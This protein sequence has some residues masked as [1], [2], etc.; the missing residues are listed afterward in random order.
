M[1]EV[2]ERHLHFEP[3]AL[4]RLD[5]ELTIS[6]ASEH[7]DPVVLARMR[8]ES[9]KNGLRPHSA[10]ADPKRVQGALIGRDAFLRRNKPVQC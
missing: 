1:P 9:L 5:Q 4:K 2:R 3:D 8:H 10:L 7:D 6:L